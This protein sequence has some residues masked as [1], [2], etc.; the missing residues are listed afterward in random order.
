MQFDRS[1]PTQFHH[2][3]RFTRDVFCPDN[4]AL[5]NSLAEPSD[6]PRRRL[7]AFIDEGVFRAT[8]RIDER[9]AEYL[10]ARTRRGERTPELKTI[11][12]VPGGEASKNSSSVVEQVLAATDRFGI[13]RKS[14]V[15]VI[16][17]GAVIDA[18]GFAAAQAHRGVRLLR[19]PTTTLAMDDAAMG[20]KHAINR[21]GKKNFIGGFTVP[22]GVLCDEDFLKTLSDRQFLEGFSEAVKIA[23]LKDPALLLQI[24]Q[25]AQAI[26]ARDL[27]AAMPVI[28]TSAQLHLDH[29]C[30]SGDPFETAEARPLDFGHW[31]AHKL[32][33]MSNFTLSHGEAVSIGIA[34]DCEYATRAGTLSRAD[35]TRV[36]NA[37]KALNLPTWH[38]LLA[39]TAQLTRGLEEFRE[40]LGG[41]LNITLLERIGAFIEVHSMDH[42]LVAQSAQALAH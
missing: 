4:D 10:A 12:V 19:L 30:Q 2:R 17:G 29:I 18:V 21:F 31:A 42:A 13:D 23:C 3:V 38:P 14:F 9:L 33:A 5:A 25:S 28:R 6:L 35:A 26:R 39:D 24:E 34:L 7:I 36:I 22:W 32:E 1:I 20:V 40:H 15:V 11:E 16:G 41:Q 37:L 8:P 27:A